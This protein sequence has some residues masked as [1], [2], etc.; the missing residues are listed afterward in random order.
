M[1]D[2]I[3]YGIIGIALLSLHASPLAWTIF[4]VGII[5]AV[6]LTIYKNRTDVC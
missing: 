1:K 4:T 2:V 5:Y 3:F 6:A